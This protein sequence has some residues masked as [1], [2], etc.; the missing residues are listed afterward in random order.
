M[1]AQRL[2]W[3]QR[4]PVAQMPLADIYQFLMFWLRRHD[5]LAAHAYA[6]QYFAIEYHQAEALRCTT[7]FEDIDISFIVHFL[8]TFRADLVNRP[9]SSDHTPHYG[10]ERR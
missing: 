3:L 4:M 9:F 6:I 5:T 8:A 7:R 2:Y 10:Y 1:I